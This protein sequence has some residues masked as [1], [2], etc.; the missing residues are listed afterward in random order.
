M[1]L[2]APFSFVV[3]L[4]VFHYRLWGMPV[5]GRTVTHNL[6]LGCC[7]LVAELYGADLQ[8]HLLVD[9]IKKWSGVVSHNL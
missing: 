7:S 8:V 6:I 4:G 9:T 3:F 1:K 5:R 2:D